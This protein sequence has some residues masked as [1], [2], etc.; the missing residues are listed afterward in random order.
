MTRCP[1]WRADVTSSRGP[2]GGPLS[3]SP[4]SSVPLSAVAWR[5]ATPGGIAVL[6]AGSEAE[7]DCWLSHCLSDLDSVH[8]GRQGFLAFLFWM[9]HRIFV[10][11]SLYMHQENLDSKVL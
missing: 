8:S 7:A 4:P 3:S 1:L 10:G 6:G 11:R 2:S 9:E 5:T